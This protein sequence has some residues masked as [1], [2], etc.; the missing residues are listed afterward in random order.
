MSWLH[1]LFRAEKLPLLPLLLPLLLLLL[2]LLPPP[3]LLYKSRLL[4][5][6]LTGFQAAAHVLMWLHQSS[7]FSRS[8]ILAE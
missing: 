5:L 2:L 7:D 3:Q 4:Y 6:L 1:L 8:R